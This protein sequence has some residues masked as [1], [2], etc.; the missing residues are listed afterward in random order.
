MTALVDAASWVLLV[1][2]ALTCVTGGVGLHRMPDFYSRT[3]AGGLTDTLGATAILFGLVLQAGL[4][5]VSVKLLMLA[6]LLH[7]TSPTATHALVKAAY[8]RGLRANEVKGGD[9]DS[10]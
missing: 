2:G 7:L 5:L 6:F 3:H 8:S 10:H 4:T 9:G 1:F